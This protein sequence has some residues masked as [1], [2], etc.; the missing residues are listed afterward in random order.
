V[1]GVF[2][3]SRSHV[4]GVIASSFANAKHT[5]AIAVAIS[6]NNIINSL[7]IFFI[8]NDQDHRAGGPTR[9]I[10]EQRIILNEGI[11]VEKPKA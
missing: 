11:D 7:F 4:N 10:V 2:V 8:D 9:V 3:F 5:T 1:I 6:K